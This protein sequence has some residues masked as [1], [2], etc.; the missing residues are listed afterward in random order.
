MKSYLKILLNS[1]ET[2]LGNLKDKNQ[3]FSP[4]IK[5]LMNIFINIF[6]GIKTVTYNELIREI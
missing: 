5:V 6:K 3:A 4:E 2:T 1:K